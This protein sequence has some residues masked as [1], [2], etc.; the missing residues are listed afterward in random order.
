MSAEAKLAEIGVTLPEVGTPRWTYVPS[1]RAANLIFVS[2]QIAVRDG[3]ALH[4]GKCGAEVSVEQGQEAA[5][6][7]AISALAVVRK[8]LGSLDGV[9]RLLKLNVYV[10]S[11]A[12]FSDQPTVANGA[13]DFLKEVFGDAGVGARTAIGVAELPLG[14]PVE[15]EFIFEAKA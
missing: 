7:C 8:E 2:G 5:R 10:A 4:A 9:A 12:G 15:C 13:A 6:G 1:V 14:A 3:K 11:A